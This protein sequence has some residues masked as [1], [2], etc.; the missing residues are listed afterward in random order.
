MNR[1]TGKTL[2]ECFIEF[3]TVADAQAALELQASRR[4]IKGREVSLVPSTQKE[5]MAA[6]FACFA[7]SDLSPDNPFLMIRN[8]SPTSYSQAASPLGS[9]ST[10]LTRD[11]IQSILTICKNYKLHFSRKCAERPF[12][13]IITILSKMPWQSYDVISLLQRDHIFEMLKSK[14]VLAYKGNSNIEMLKSCP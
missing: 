8:V 5:F 13:F 3:A 10:F 11:D 2:S 1:S 14:S 9:A 12:E 4:I 7:I 6:L